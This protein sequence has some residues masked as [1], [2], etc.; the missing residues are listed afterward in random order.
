MLNIS[1]VDQLILD[2]P[3]EVLQRISFSMPW[4]SSSGTGEHKDPDGFDELSIAKE[5]TPR[6]RKALQAEVFQKFHR[7]PHI[8]TSVRGLVGRMTGLGFETTSGIQEIQ[9]VIEMIELD[10]RNRLY[11]F[12][13]KYVGRYLVE[14][15]MYLM[16]TL[17]SDG[18]VEI[19][20]V[21]PAS[22]HDAGDDGSGIIF[23]PS[24][25]L[26]PLFYNISSGTDRHQ[27]PSIYIARYPELV[28]VARDNKDFVLAHQ[29]ASK[30]RKKA[31]QPLRGYYR[32]MLSFEKGLMT[33][34]AISYLRSVIEWL[35]YYENLKKYEIDYKKAAGAYCWV[36]RITDAKSFKI[37]LT[38]SDE[39]KRKTGIMAKKT[40]GGSLVLPPGIECEVVTPQLTS[41]RD[42]DTDILQMVA[43]GLNESADVLTGTPSG[44]YSSVRAT[45]GPMTDRVSDEIAYWDRFLKY[46][47]WSSIFF[48]RSA[49]G[50]GKNV[51]KVKRAVDFNENQEPV[52]KEVN[53]LAEQLVD[54]SYPT[55]EIA[56]Y[57]SK[58]R[59]FLGVK[60]GPI[61][62][63]LGIP[64]SVLARIM[65][66]AGYA[67]ARLDKATEDDMYPELDYQTGV[68][69]ESQQESNE[70]EPGNSVRRAKRTPSNDN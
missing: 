61:A 64:N 26:M 51:Y 62:E 70:G 23:H 25:A 10:K 54:I 44:N 68:D 35:N 3:D 14:G 9:E 42:E 40:P 55:S 34:R 39:D 48:L 66:F 29:K 49:I 7:N 20:F 21:D 17:H 37:W 45:R 30:T 65:G 1:E 53:K 32:F 41:I 28:N 47:F 57:E 59:A 69:A 46:D 15:E 18:F 60:H 2:M 22:I 24:K 8:N 27:V 56:E 36:F 12:W 33:K 31:F 6:D 38:M 11:Y 63:T 13:P 43:S 19:D 16:L 5:D 58:A 67:R 4:Q 50:K 52:F